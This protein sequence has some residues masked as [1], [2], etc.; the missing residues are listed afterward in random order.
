MRNKATQYIK[1][2]VSANYQISTTKI[3]ARRYVP[4]ELLVYFSDTIRN[5]PILTVVIKM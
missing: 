2:N 1:P 4:T 3:L 5:E